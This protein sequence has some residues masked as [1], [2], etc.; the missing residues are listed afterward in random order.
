MFYRSIAPSRNS[1]RPTNLLIL[2]LIAF[3]MAVSPFRATTDIST[4][5]VQFIDLSAAGANIQLLGGADAD[6]LSG[7]GVADSFSTFPRSHAIAAGDINN[8]GIRDLIVGAPDVDFTPQGGTAR[9]N[10][11]AVYIIFGKPI[12]T[13]PTIIDANATATSQPDVKIFGPSADDGLGF[14][15]AAGDVNGDG[16]DDL[17]IGA[18]GFDLTGAGVA[19]PRNNTGAVFIIFGVAAFTPRTIDLATANAAN[20]QVIGER[21][22]DRFGSALAIGEANGGTSTPDLFVGAPGSKGPDPVGS[23]RTNGGAAFLLFG[24]TA[25]ANALTTT[26]VIDL[27]V[28]TAPVRIFGKAESQL[29]SA[30]AIGDVNGGGAGDLL[31]GAPKANRPDTIEVSQTGATFGVFGGANLNASPP[32]TTKSFDISTTQQNL[33]IYGETSGDHLGAAV[34][35]GDVTNEGASDIII[36]APQSAGPA[37]LRPSCGQG[38]VIA[39]G[40]ALNPAGGATETR[41]NISISTA[42]LTVVGAAPGDRLGSAAAAG[43]VNTQ[44]NTDRV[45]DVLFGAPGALSNRGSVH[46]FFGGSNLLIFAARDL[47]LNQD[48]LRI[49]GQNSG[50]EFG[51]AIATGDF[52][53]NLGGDIA[54]GAPFADI[55]VAGAATRADAGKVY[56][57]LASADNVPPENHPPTVTVTAP[58]GGELIVGGSAFQIKWDASDPDGNDTIQ[59]FD[60]TLSTDGGT[61]FNTIIASNLSG[62][63]RSVTWNVPIGVNTEAA[64]VRVTVTDNAAATAHD[65]SADFTINDNGIALAVLAPNGGEILRFGQTFKIS[66]VV[67]TGFEDQVK[68]FDVFYTTDG[69]ATFTAI[70]VINPLQPALPADVRELDWTV[71]RFCTPT[72]KVLV[73]A[74]SKTNAVSSDSSNSTFSINEVG[75]QIDTSEMSFNGSAT[76]LNFRVVSGSQP[77]FLPGVKFEISSNQVGS[78]FFEVEKA[79]VKGS[80]KKLQTRGDINGQEVGVFFPDG[81]HRILRFT[82]P[83]CGTTILRVTRTGDQLV[84]DAAL[85]EGTPIWQ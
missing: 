80:G 77:R 29:G 45:P 76:K 32:A 28:S 60:V 35:V 9:V 17:A 61:T 82:N 15:V 20:D 62:L 50:D 40:D 37:G 19:E 51:W 56:V 74:T 7:N 46:G 81:D 52:D 84:V 41:I 47:A 2:G 43:V 57:L 5:T 27:G 73:T 13:F 42:S 66:W 31:V 10:A 34:A 11:G 49:T 53:N 58:A 14:S 72:A 30:L 24:G 38:Y 12:F 8:D 33:S 21:A 48:D 22:D 59:G 75:P 79:K 6:H 36:G 64:R 18:P 55:P 39:G 65:D 1:L 25:L 3:A 78:Q 69:G 23:A 26:K 68:G 67:G 44:G 4:R 71:P 16:I 83:T 85:R 63:L 54:G 70:T